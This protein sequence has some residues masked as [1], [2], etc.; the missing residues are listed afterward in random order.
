MS[1]IGLSA[2]P[3]GKGFAISAYADIRHEQLFFERQQSLTLRNMEWEDRIKPMT[4]W[5]ALILRGLG[6]AVLT[7]AILAVLI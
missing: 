5:S 7:Y 1:A 2:A 3:R 6:V 4:S